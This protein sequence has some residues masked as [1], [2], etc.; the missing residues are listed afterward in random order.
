VEPPEVTSVLLIPLASASG[1]RLV[2]TKRSIL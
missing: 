2:P 1:I